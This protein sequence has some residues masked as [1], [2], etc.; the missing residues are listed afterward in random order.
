MQSERTSA[1]TSEPSVLR[2]VFIHGTWGHPRDWDDALR[3]WPDASPPPAQRALL[4]AHG[5]RAPAPDEPLFEQMVEDLRR[6]LDPN[7]SIL[8]GYSLGGRVALAALTRMSSTERAKIRGLVLEGVHPG[9]VDDEARRE[10]RQLDEARAQAI[11]TQSAEA[12]LDQWYQQ[13]IFGALAS[14]DARRSALVHERAKTLDPSSIARVFGECSPGLVPPQWDTLKELTCPILFVVGEHDAR[15]R[16]VAQ[17][18]ANA[19]PHVSVATIP[20]AG[21]NTHRDAPEA[22][23]GEVARFI[24][25][26]STRAQR[27]DELPAL[28]R[29]NLPPSL[30]L[31]RRP[32]LLAVHKAP[33]LLVHNSQWAGPPEVTL[34]DLLED[35]LH[36]ETWPLHRLD[37]GTSGLLLCLDDLRDARAWNDAYRENKVAREYLA[38]V[39]GQIH[40]PIL[41][42]RPI[43][44][45]E[46]NP[47]DARSML[48]P[49]ARS[50]VA[51]VTLV[52][53]RIWTGR[54]HQ[55]R[56]H[57]RSISHHI[58]G[59][60]N[61]GNNKFNR[62]MREH[63][64]PIT[65]LALHSWRVAMVAPD[66]EMLHFYADPIGDF[67]HWCRELFTLPSWEALRALPWLE[68][69]P[70]DSSA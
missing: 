26:V 42:E 3:A 31:A 15:Y 32:P 66:G 56:R 65:R 37:R 51:R 57:M 12:F 50:S 54:R 20:N 9:L 22:F 30:V 17:D 5:G 60:A 49:I 11:A 18:I 27:R 68:A 25:K 46:G 48:E 41:I 10:R 21:H 45:D 39:R 1:A 53:V 70:P 7:P 24:E 13:P 62:E 14:D 69:T 2:A 43:P 35:E 29:D 52:R 6:Q 58:V 8:I 61:W 55:I 67:A 63:P 28:V 19:C 47:L 44:D 23:S 16:A 59:D 4:L 40:A 36:Q 34:R 33:G 64:V 38:I